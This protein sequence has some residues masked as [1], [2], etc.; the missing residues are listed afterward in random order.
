VRARLDMEVQ[1]RFLLPNLFLI[2]L[3]YFR[4]HTLLESTI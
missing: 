3:L 4:I 1:G 2:F